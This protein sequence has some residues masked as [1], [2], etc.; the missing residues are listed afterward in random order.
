VSRHP[1]QKLKLRRQPV[2]RQQPAAKINRPVQPRKLPAQYRR[3]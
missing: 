3:S 1:K 2:P